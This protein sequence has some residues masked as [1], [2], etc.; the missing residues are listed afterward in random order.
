MSPVYTE[1]SW[2]TPPVSWPAYGPVASATTIPVAS[3]VNATA[4]IKGKLSPAT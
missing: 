3:E 2:A 4:R 1:A